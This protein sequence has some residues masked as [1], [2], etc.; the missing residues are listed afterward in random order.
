MRYTGRAKGEAR[1]RRASG[2]AGQE[3]SRL[4]TLYGRRD[5]DG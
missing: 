3:W 4:A 2:N 5:A 1:T